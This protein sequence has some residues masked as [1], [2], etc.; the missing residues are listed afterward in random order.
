MWQ[1]NGLAVRL[2]S[3][4][5]SRTSDEGRGFDFFRT[6]VA[7]NLNG[8][9]ESSFWT[10]D[11]LQAAQHEPSIH[12]AV[13][14]LASLSETLL[15]NKAEHENEEEKEREHTPEPF[16]I[17]QHSKAISSLS[18]NLRDG[19]EQCSEVVLITCALFICFEMFQNKHESAL[20]QISSGAYVFLDWHSKKGGASSN[21]RGISSKLALQ[22]QHIFERLMLQAILFIET[23]PQE[24]YFLIPT[25]TPAMPSIPSIF[26]TMEEARDCLNNCLCSI[27]HGA[28]ACQLYGLETRQVRSGVFDEWAQAFR[29]FMALKK[30]SLSP[31]EQQAAIILEIQQITGSIL[32]SA[33]AFTQETIFDSFEHSFSRIVSLA[34]DLTTS[35]SE[36]LQD[37]ESTFPSFDMGIL[38]PL[39]FVASRCRHPLIRRQALHLL[40]KGPSQEGIWNKLMLSNIVERLMNLEEVDCGKVERS[41][42]IRASARLSVL[43]ARI[44]SVQRTVALHGCRQ[45]FEGPGGTEVV[46]ELVAY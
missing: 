14:A 11:I 38:P 8:F 45:R 10:H 4:D 37:A 16:A 34:F 42:D 29:S 31:R 28:M 32:A 40:R 12:H 6:R 23:K 18:K 35:S 5:P 2:L 39:Y 36:K 30:M 7:V 1:P 46:H 19:K 43:N 22:L 44:N 33:G 27:Y 25:F 9:F 13:V 17:K 41:A 15:R 24:W 20:G 3:P 26:K 21:S